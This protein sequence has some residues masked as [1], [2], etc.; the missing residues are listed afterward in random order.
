MNNKC[1]KCGSV[2]IIKANEDV[3]ICLACE[4]LLNMINGENKSS[5]FDNITVSPEV[6]AEKLVYRIKQLFTVPSTS[7]ENPGGYEFKTTW[8]ST[9]V[10]GEFDSKEEAITAT[11]EKLKGSVR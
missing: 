8:F 3:N 1:P 10:D 2:R 11:V 6:L 4:S 5:I 7:R 9:I